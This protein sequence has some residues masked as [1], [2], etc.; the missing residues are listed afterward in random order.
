MDDFSSGIAQAV[1]I[2]PD[3][4]VLKCSNESVTIVREIMDR[5]PAERHPS[6]LIVGATKLDANEPQPVNVETIQ[7]ADRIECHGLQLDRRK[8]HA[9]IDGRELTLT[10]MEFQ[11]LWELA[12]TPGHVQTRDDLVAACRR[13]KTI[14]GR[15]TIDQHIRSLRKKLENRGDL[16]E[17]VRGVGYRFRDCSDQEMIN[18]CVRC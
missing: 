9:A 3:Y 1:A 7:H 17:T 15:R 18:G 4:V 13:E 8:L 11:I 16:I 12:L 14:V 6:F 10:L 2:A 5:L